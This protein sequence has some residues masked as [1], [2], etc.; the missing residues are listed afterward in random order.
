MGIIKKVTDA[1]GE[2]GFNLAKV[3]GQQFLGQNTDTQSAESIPSGPAHFAPP[4]PSPSG[5]V[6]APPL[7][8]SAPASPPATP[9]MP[10]GPNATADVVEGLHK[11]GEMYKAG[12][13]TE[14]EFIQAKSR[15]LG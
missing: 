9:P 1:L 4:P 15:L 6:I 11:L 13:L 2:D 12:L 3:A 14:A 7:V 10:P 8:Y 5:Q